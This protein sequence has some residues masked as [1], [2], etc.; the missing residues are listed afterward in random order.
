MDADRQL[1][2]LIA[3]VRSDDDVLAA[4][5]FGS[6]ARGDH[7]VGSDVDV[8]LVLASGRPGGASASRKQLAYASQVDLDVHVFQRLPLYIRRRVLKEG[9]VLFVRDEDALYDLAYR[10]ARAY[11]SFRPRYEAYLAEVARARS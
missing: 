10:T 11:E 8:C 5:L 6:R 3:L 2:R 9:R 7:H 1:E 4:I